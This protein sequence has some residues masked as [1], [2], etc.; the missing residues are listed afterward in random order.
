[1]RTKPIKE[2]EIF[3]TAYPNISIAK[4]KDEKIVEFK[5]GVLGEKCKVK[6]TRSRGSKSKGK[7]IEK[8]N[9]SKYEN[10]REFCPNA[11]ICGGCSYQK[12][13]YET[14]LLVKHDMIKKLLSNID[15]KINDLSIA[16]SPKIKAYRNKME[17]TFGDSYKDGPLTLG[18]HRINRFYEIVDTEGCNIVD[19]DFEI[20]RK[21]VQ[22]YFRERNTSFYHKKNHQGLL[23]NL[24][25][26]KAMHTNEIMVILVTSSD[27]SFD[28]MRKDLF[29]HNL[30]NAKTK[31]LIKSIYHVIND[32]LA[33]AVKV[34]SIELL[35]GKEYIKEKINDLYFKISPFS[36]FQP[37]VFTAE[38]IYNKAIELSSVDKTKNVLDLYSGTGTLTQTFAK[39]ANKALGIEIVEEAVEKAFVN[40]KENKIENIDFIAGDVLE[41]IDLVKGNYDIVVIDP[42]R[43]GIHPK[44]I[45][46]I[47]DINPEEF[48][49]ISCNPKTQVRDIEIF[50]EKGYRLDKYQAFDQFPRSRHVETVALLKRK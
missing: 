42:P 41:K 7:Y 37:N 5:G 49:Y 6:I 1:M 20:I 31:G 24:I 30:L 40:A 47:I 45:G 34:D 9:D 23:R 10:Y 18:L 46:K 32:S 35:F 25:I 14:E 17:Y 27:K 11:G 36:F 38:K 13:G 4:D 50:K 48:V 16:R 22:T 21:H 26:R 43:E 15:I 33:D 39:S 29:A 12:F 3:D 8:I 44:A 2:V 28:P 19:E